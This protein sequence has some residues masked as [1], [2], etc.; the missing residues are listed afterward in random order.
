VKIYTKGGDAGETGLIDG[1]RVPK[2]DGR[3]T[4][5]GEVDELNAVLGLARA[6]SP[7][8]AVRTLLHDIQ[9]D[10]FALGA[11][12][13][14]P[15]AQIGA[16]KP[17][18]AVAAAQIEALERAIDE[19]QAAMPPLRAFLLPGGVPAAAFL[20]LGRTVCRR[21]ERATVSLA[22]RE[23]VDPLV[24]AYL[25]RLSDLLFVL[26]REANLRAGEAE[27]RW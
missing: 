20:H 7:D 5:Y 16:R 23:K 25:N 11:Q 6:H 3:V 9:K 17:K 24:L 21:A 8:P 27:E 15:Q 13:A 2:D 14:D 19:R 4:A 12:L 18:A 26:A 1:S 22:R 10:L